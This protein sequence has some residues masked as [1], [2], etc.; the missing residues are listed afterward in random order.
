MLETYVL[1]F[2]ILLFST[3]LL[4]IYEKSLAGG[5]TYPAIAFKTLAFLILLIPAAI[6]YRVGTDYWAYIEIFES[7]NNR[8]TTHVESGYKY[9]NLLLG[10]LGLSAQWL[11]ASTSL[12]T[13]FFV[14]KALPRK[15]GWFVN[16]IFITLCYLY[17][18]SNFRTGIVIG[19][20]FYAVMEYIKKE[21]K[22]KL[23]FFIFLSALFHKSALLYLIIIPLMSRPAISLFSS[24]RYALVGF[25][26][27]VVAGIFS[28]EIIS[29]VVSFGLVQL[30]GYSY[31][32]D[33]ALYF[34]DPKLGTGLGVIARS[35]PLILFLALSYKQLSH[36]RRLRI[37]WIFSLFF[38][39]LI[40]ISSVI[41]ILSR[42]ENL[43][44]PLYLIVGYFGFCELI[45]TR[46]FA[47]A[48]SVVF[49][50][51][52]LF[53]KDIDGS[54]SDLCNGIRISP[55]VSIFNM[56][57]DNSLTVDRNVCGE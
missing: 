49:V 50:L 55:Y 20:M 39:F 33:N 22:A 4:L 2:C 1:Y 54:R 16:I 38:L 31:Y 24:R 53:T 14:Y 34:S 23:I 9:F 5:F 48:I 29:F 47:Y 51:L 21:N 8:E 19:I 25:F 35:T 15:G 46:T 56:E 13:Y 28:R 11:V 27:V 42:L 17:T 44:F 26:V 18:F 36:N 40:S 57:D 10:N 12:I 30:F 52:I 43:F 3:I 7:I 37:G 6:R 41:E 32:V 45:K